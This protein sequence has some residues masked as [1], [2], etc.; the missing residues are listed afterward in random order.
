[1]NSCFYLSQVTS[2]SFIPRTFI[3]NVLL[4]AP[5]FHII[6]KSIPLFTNKNYTHYLYSIKKPLFRAIFLCYYAL[7][8]TCIILRN[9]LG[10]DK[11]YIFKDF[12]I[13]APLLHPHSKFTIY[14][15]INKS[16]ATTI[17]L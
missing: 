11:T 6:N 10:T 2:T 13:I 1:M 4:K 14:Y 5:L 3:L 15:V 8:N 9:D 16:L 12:I 17:F 7:Q